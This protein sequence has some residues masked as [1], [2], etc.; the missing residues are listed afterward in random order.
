MIRRAV[1]LATFAALVGC[2]A[3]TPPA[4]NA[5]DE[6]IESMFAEDPDEAAQKSLDAFTSLVTEEDFAALGFDSLEEVADAQ[7][8]EPLQV[9]M[10]PLDLLKEFTQETDPNELLQDGNRVIYPVTVNDEVRSSLEIGPIGGGWQGTTFGS[11]ELIRPLAEQRARA[12]DFVVWVPALNMYFMAVR[13]G[14]QLILTPAFDYPE[15]NLVAGRTQSASDV[16]A[17]IQPLA[18]SHEELP[19]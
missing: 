9:S 1:I 14:E 6:T 12:E 11:P 5:P 19:T 13:D 2:T 17:A 18:A 10:V 8:G 16:F 7:L 3:S 15:A 4:S